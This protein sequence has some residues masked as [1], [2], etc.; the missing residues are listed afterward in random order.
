M[1]VSYDMYIFYESF[2]Y[3]SATLTCNNTTSVYTYTQKGENPSSKKNKK[4]VTGSDHGNFTIAVDTSQN[5]IYINRNTGELL[6][7]TRKRKS[8]LID[9]ITN[10]KWQLIDDSV[11]TIADYTCYLAQGYFRGCVYSVWYTP[12][13]PSSF[14]PWKLN[15][16][17]GLILEATRD[18]KVLSFYATKIVS[19]NKIITTDFNNK[20]LKSR[21]L[22]EKEHIDYLNKNFEQI[23]ASQTRGSS[24]MPYYISCLECDFLDE[25]LRFSSISIRKIV[26]DKLTGDE[27]EI[28]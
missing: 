12:D 13:I 14:G 3:Y 26:T 28:K 23:I 16:C 7:Y 11:K 10:I 21:E 1:A 25:L 6:D 18:D 2:P 15:G 20:P 5:V 4:L 22:Y 9:T 27:P 24:I 8:V 17:P 19:E